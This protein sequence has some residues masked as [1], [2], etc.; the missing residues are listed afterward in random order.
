LRQINVVAGTEKII[1]PVNE[2][3][4]LP[5]REG[6]CR[7]VI[8]NVT[9]EID[10]G[11]FAIKRVTGE[12]VVVEADIFADGHD[13]LAAV[14]KFR[15]AENSEWGETPMELLSNDR[16]HGEFAV[17]KSGN[18]F[19]TIEAWVDQFKSWQKIFKK[20]SQ[21]GKIFPSSWKRAQNGSKPLR[22]AHRR[23]T[24]KIF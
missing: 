2:N 16:W 8:E 24:L 10:G 17:A 11:R 20:R 3:P 12:R 7:V 4:T 14:L 9:P 6:R 1:L 19:Y 23:A 15:A 21:P 18:Y 5:E 13:L 22:V